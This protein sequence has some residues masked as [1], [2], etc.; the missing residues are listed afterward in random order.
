[1]NAT[2]NAIEISDSAIRAAD[3]KSSAHPQPSRQPLYM[4]T[5]VESDRM[6]RRV[7]GTA[8]HMTGKLGEF[9]QGVTS[10]GS[11]VL[12]TATTTASPFTTIAW[13]QQADKLSVS[14]NGPIGHPLTK[15]E[16][17]I[18]LFLGAVGF[19][20]PPMQITITNTPPIAKG[21]GSS[22]ADMGAALLVASRFCG[23]ASEHEA[24]YRL[25]CKVERSDFLFRPDCLV[26]ANP[27]SGDVAAGGPAPRLLLVGWDSDP[28]GTVDTQAVAHLDCKR[29]QHADEYEQLIPLLESGDTDAVLRAITRSA[30]LNQGL[31]P[32]PGF[33]WA[34][35]VAQ[36][37]GTAVLVAHTGTYMALAVPS[38][39]SEPEFI[40]RLF[41]LVQ[42]Q[43]YQPEFFQ[44]GPA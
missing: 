25:M 27:V 2:K 24:L 19:T 23:L 4:I 43:G 39:R 26:R 34:H 7:S 14:S 32:K 28:N 22:S 33:S 3:G 1:M 38:D 15:T 9:L 11:P 21:L 8:A 35:K 20:V 5:G 31:L 42:S 13:A 30:E 41:R 44:T 40:G 17:A 37:T 36:D 16:R 12:Y 10:D 18:R 29:L 6:Q